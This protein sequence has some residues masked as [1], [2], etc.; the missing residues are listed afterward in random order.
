M[1]RKEY[2]GVLFIVLSFFSSCKDN[3]KKI[4]TTTQPASVEEGVVIMPSTP[5]NT[6]SFSKSIKAYAKGNIGSAELTISYYSPAVRGRIIWG[7]LVPFGQVWVTGAHNATSLETNADLLVGDKKLA[8]GK[9][10]LF[11]IPGEE[12]WIFIVNKNWQQ[13]LADNYRESE[14]IFRLQVK[15][16]SLKAKQERLMYQVIS[17]GDKAGSLEMHWENIKIAVPLQAVTKD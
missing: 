11:T 14:D 2:L 5:G 8:A 10:A 3:D 1:I 12:E 17:S 7:G 6:D 4:E 9:Y 16:D 13:H 15:P